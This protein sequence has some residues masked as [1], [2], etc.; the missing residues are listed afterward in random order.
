[1]KSLLRIPAAIFASICLFSGCHSVTEVSGSV[2][3]SVTF[4]ST[5]DFTIVD[6]LD[7]ITDGRSIC[8]INNT[9]FFVYNA[10]GRLYRIDSG[11]MAI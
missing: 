7:G 11:E 3:S 4:I 9:L 5:S 2:Q 6:T 1:M 8:S 10:Y